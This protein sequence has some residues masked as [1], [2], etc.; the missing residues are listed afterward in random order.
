M[1]W[2]T[3]DPTCGRT[4]PVARGLAATALLEVVIYAGEQSVQTAKQRTRLSGSEL[5]SCTGNVVRHSA[6][7]GLQ[8]I[9]APL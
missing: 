8:K 2:L 1:G 7:S 3:V 4:D 5:R 6:V 9:G